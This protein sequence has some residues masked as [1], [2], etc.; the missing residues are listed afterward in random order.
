MP[1]PPLKNFQDATQDAVGMTRNLATDGYSCSAVDKTVT[2]ISAERTG[3]DE[4]GK[5][6]R[7]AADVDD[8]EEKA[9]LT[10]TTS[11]S[12]TAD[13]PIRRALNS[14]LVVRMRVTDKMDNTLGNMHGGCAATLV[15]NISSMPIFYHTSGVYGQP[16]SFLG[17]SQNIT[18]LYLNACPLGSVIEMEVYTEQI[19]K[20]IAVIKAEFWIV[21][22]DDGTEDDG[23]GP[24]HTGKWKRVTKT[25]VGSHTK[26]DNSAKIKL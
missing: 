17:V 23:E 3:L 7:E 6:V 12:A 22:R 25:V 21:V 20:N 8:S 10:M 13:T 24:V 1:A 26:V 11:G 5:L 2:I 9:R 4:N 18:V 19:G 16:W 14:R 15:D